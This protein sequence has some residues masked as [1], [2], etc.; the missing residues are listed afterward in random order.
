MFL[1]SFIMQGIP[2]LDVG[3]M[4][5][6]LHPIIVFF[7][8]L[9]C[10][11]SP[12]SYFYARGCIMRKKLT[13]KDIA[14]VVGVSP[15]TVSRAL[16]G[17]N[18]LPQKTIERIRKTAAEMGYQ[19]NALA[20]HLARNRSF[21]IAYVVPQRRT[22]KGPLQVSYFSTILDAMV[23]EAFDWKYDITIVNYD[24]ESSELVAKLANRV[25]SRQVDGLVFIGLRQDTSFVKE[26]SEKE[27]PFVLIGNRYSSSKIVTVCSDPY[28]AH[29]EMLKVLSENGYRRLFFVHGDL[30]YYHAI[31]QRK[32][33][34]KAASE[35]N[36]DI[37]EVIEG[38]Y[39]RRSGYSAAAYIMKKKKNSDAVF[40]ANDRM[41]SGFYRY[42]YEHGVPIPDE[43]GIIGSDCDEAA[44]ALYPDLSSIYQP[45]MEM[46]TEA[47]RLLVDIIEKG[48][49]R[50][51]IIP[52]SFVLKKSLCSC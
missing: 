21:N 42:C 2:A 11:F 12:L 23:K 10:I 44:T 28:P 26:L 29:M 1:S 40:L 16:S 47:V 30:G 22:R 6:P 7:A 9:S 41:A 17:S 4:M 33:L 5:L 48:K 27:I 37:A 25:Y 52:K 32:A 15:S 36:F 50:S 51:V 35:T 31:S 19:P 13:R 46:G 34:L 45:R 49:K 38:N 3:S 18:L 14:T 8:F 24:E 43:I 39:T 20:R